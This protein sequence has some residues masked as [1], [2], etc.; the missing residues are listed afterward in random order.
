MSGIFLLLQ[1]LVVS[2]AI[3]VVTFARLHAT[4]QEYSK[5]MPPL[6]P[7][8]A[9]GLQV[10]R[11]TRASRHNHSLMCSYSYHSLGEQ[12]VTLLALPSPPF[13]TF[14]L[15]HLPP[16]IRNEIWELCISD[17][18]F[19]HFD[20]TSNSDRHRCDHP[21]RFSSHAVYTRRKGCCRSCFPPVFSIVFAN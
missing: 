5:H 2:A 14:P 10:S 11:V 19:P 20:I 4:S 9:K 8:H 1:K 16:E 13:S 12:K 3:R 15:L 18:L 6:L 7:L 17:V 21:V